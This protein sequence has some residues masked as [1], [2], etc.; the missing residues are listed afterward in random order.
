MKMSDY[1]ALKALS[2]GTCH[3]L[4]TASPLH[5]WINSPWCPDRVDDSNNA[6]DTGTTAHAGIL[7]GNFNSIAVIDPEKHRSKPTKDNPEGAIP[8]GWTNGAIRAAA[9]QARMDGLTPILKDDMPAIE[10]MVSTVRDFIEHSALKGLFANGEPEQTVTWDDNGVPCKARP[11]YLTPD[12]CLHLK[13][14]KMS[15]EPRRFERLCV[16]MGYD[17]SVAFYAR[18]I[19]RRDHLILA[20]E[21]DA[22]HACK[23]F[24]LSSA[25]FDI[26]MTRIERAIRTWDAC[27]KSGKFPAYS[28][29][30]HYIEPTNWQLAEA[31]R[32]IVENDQIY[33]LGYDPTIANETGVQA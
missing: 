12:V 7:E 16:N 5:A 3:T 2:S 23:I 31:E 10:R 14:T 20:V 18:G 8:K 1:I 19:E 24:G 28:G 9:L 30:I 26:S 27:M 11:D 15:V 6:S 32:E 25:Q 17:L 13:T 22:P 4:L 29:E 33:G 21:Q